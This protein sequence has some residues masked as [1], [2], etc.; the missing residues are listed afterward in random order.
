MGTLVWLSA[1]HP[2]PYLSL[3]GKPGCLDLESS[4]QREVWAAFVVPRVLTGGSSTSPCPGEVA[5]ARGH[6]GFTLG[7]GGWWPG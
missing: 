2:H 3:L 6:R 5:N 7:S 4:G 1:T